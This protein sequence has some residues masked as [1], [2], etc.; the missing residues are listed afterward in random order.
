MRVMDMRVIDMSSRVDTTVTEHMVSYTME[1]M[2]A[3]GTIPRW[4]D[5][6]GIPISHILGND[7]ID[8]YADR[9]GID[10]SSHEWLSLVIRVARSLC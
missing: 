6:D 1:E 4:Y 7:R 10:P 3:D 8:R 2:M 5:T 9:L